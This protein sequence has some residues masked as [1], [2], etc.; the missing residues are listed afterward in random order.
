[1][2]RS[3]TRTERNAN[4]SQNWLTIYRRTWKQSVPRKPAPHAFCATWLGTSA[5]AEIKEPRV[6]PINRFSSR[7]QRLDHAFLSAKLQEA[8]SYKRIAGH[9]RSSIFELVG[10]EIAGI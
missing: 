6:P 1:M 7:R 2:C 8:K 10:E 3:T 5:L 9:F 4:W